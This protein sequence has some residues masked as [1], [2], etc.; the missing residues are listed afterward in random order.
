MV[1][2]D[3]VFVAKFKYCSQCFGTVILDVVCHL[4]FFH[5]YYMKLF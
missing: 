2:V 3:R 5:T 1:Y 4:V